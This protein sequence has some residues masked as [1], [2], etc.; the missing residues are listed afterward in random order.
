M[1][2]LSYVGRRLL[3]LI[4]VGFGCTLV[5]FFMVHLIPGDPARTMLGIRATEANVERLHK[6]WGLD[7]PLINQYWD[8]LG[9]LAHGD[10]GTSLFYGLEVRQLIMDR[11]GPT[12]WLM[13]L[14]MLFAVLIAVPLATLAA[15]KKN[16]LRDQIIRFVPLFGLGMP[17]FW[18]G[19]ILLL[20]FALNTGRHFPVGGYGHGFTG[21]LHSMI[22][23]ALTIAV[24]LAPI[25]IRSLRASLLDVLESDYITTARSKGIPERRVI[26]RHAVRNSVISMVTVLGLNMAYLVG[27]TVVVE[28]VFAIPGIGSLMLDAVFQRDFTVVQAVTLAFAILVV[29][30]NLITDIVHSLLDPRVR[31]D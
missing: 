1:D 17:A 28:K 31:F 6:E 19:I 12:L 10:L 21:H 13:G 15:T 2:R 9:R 7:Q 27:G 18:L 20:V 24:F 23:P 29:L 3:Q 30:I 5:V 22:L 8:F 14:A 26:I 4:P 16:G 25:L 11:V